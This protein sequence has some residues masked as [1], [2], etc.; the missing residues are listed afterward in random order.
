VAYWQSVAPTEH[1]LSVFAQLWAQGRENLTMVGFTASYPGLGAYP[2]SLLKPGEVVKDLYRVP[3]EIS[4]TTPS[5]LQVHLGLFEYGGVDEGALPSVDSAG[6]PAN[7]LVGT[8]RLLPQEPKRYDISRPL[9]FDLGDQAALLGYDLS[10]ELLTA[11]DAITVTLYWEAL[12]RMRDDYK[13]FVHL[14]GPTPDET[15][16][17]QS[18][19]LPLDGLWPTSAWESGYPIRDKYRLDLPADLAPGRYELRAG[20]YRPE[21][22]QRVPVLSP[23]ELAKDSAM[24][25]TQVDV[26]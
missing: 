8:V 7:G 20:L 22:G 26:R 3:V 15:I 10:K 25:L 11:G 17:A 16:A 18:D 6:Q 19:K 13:V 5:L 14:V 4:A 12:K 23:T 24:I 9:R 21:D 1:D 2:T